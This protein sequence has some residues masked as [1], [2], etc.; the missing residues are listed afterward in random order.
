MSFNL[1]LHPGTTKD[2]QGI[3]SEKQKAGQ[4]GGGLDKD[5]ALS[6]HS[7]CRPGELTFYSTSGWQKAQAVLLCDSGCSKPRDKL[8]ASPCDIYSI[9]RFET[10]RSLLS[11]EIKPNVGS[12]Q[13]LKFEMNFPRDICLLQASL[14]SAVHAG[15][16]WKSLEE[17]EVIWLIGGHPAGHPCPCCACLLECLSSRSLPAKVCLQ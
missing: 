4:P 14:D 10:K 15:G 13:G 7:V 8:G 5:T 9:Q 17:H 1:F 6:V 16:L 3:K 2:C 11:C 12:K